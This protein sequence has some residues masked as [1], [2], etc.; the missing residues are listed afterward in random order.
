LLGDLDQATSGGARPQGRVQ[1][2]ESDGHSAARVRTARQQRQ[3]LALGL[4]N[5]VE[6]EPASDLEA[7]TFQAVA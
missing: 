3:R 6:T 5:I 4:G 2:G 1:I 7:V